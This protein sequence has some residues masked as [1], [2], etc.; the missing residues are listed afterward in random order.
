M[1]IGHDV[2]RARRA[3]HVFSSTLDRELFPSSAGNINHR[4]WFGSSFPKYIVGM[5]RKHKSPNHKSP[6]SSIV[7]YIEFNEMWSVLEYNNYIKKN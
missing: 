6:N 5:I 4:W 3:L 1:L 2:L 7:K